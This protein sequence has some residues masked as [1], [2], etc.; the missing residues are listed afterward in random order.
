MEQITK[1]IKVAHVIGMAINGGTE[2][3]WMNYYRNIDR[4][5]VQIDFLVESESKI[6]NKEEIENL[7]GH[8]VIIPPYKN[9]F[10]YIK[11]LK[12]IFIE[13]QYDIVH[14]NMNALSVFTLKAA[15]KAKIKV[16]IAH[17]HSTSNKKEWK[18]NIVKNLLRPFSKKYAT[19]YFACSEHAGRWLFG[20]KT[21]DQGKVTIIKNAIDI[22]KFKYNEQNRLDIRKEFN[23]LDDEFLIGNVGRMMPQKNQSF[24]LDV[25][26]KYHQDNPKSKL[27]IINDGP[28][29]EELKAKVETLNIKD[30]VIFVGPKSDLFRYY[31]AFDVFTLPSLYEGLGIVLVEAQANGLNCLA[32]I[33]VPREA[34]GTCN[35]KFVEL[36][37]EKWVDELK[38]VNTNRNSWEECEESLIKSQYSIKNAVKEIENIYTKLTNN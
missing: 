3:L 37:E 24:L 10:K 14:S 29:F 4:T 34:D 6:I 27:M 22:E 5:K 15:K 31:S 11:T 28:L 25:F 21:Y 33:N 7:G 38:S 23:V 17:S 8:V 19:D 9:V 30:S 35:V 1:P 2:A 12:K 18:K 13:N 20:D 16:R 36:D 32:S 26:A